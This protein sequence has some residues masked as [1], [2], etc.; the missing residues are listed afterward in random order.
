M[1][2]PSTPK[3]AIS[4]PWSYCGPNSQGSIPASSVPDA[5]QIPLDVLFQDALELPVGQ[6]PQHGVSE[7]ITIR[8]Q[9]VLPER[10]DPTVTLAVL[11]SPPE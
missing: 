9:N 3:P 7:G 6:R 8:T 11:S 5:P 4:G 2:H 10:L 1:I